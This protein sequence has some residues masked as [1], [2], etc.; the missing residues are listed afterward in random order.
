MRKECVVV[1][2][3]GA[4][5]VIDDCHGCCKAGRPAATWDVMKGDPHF[6]YLMVNASKI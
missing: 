2:E 1:L 6:S 3:A 5:S 4:Y